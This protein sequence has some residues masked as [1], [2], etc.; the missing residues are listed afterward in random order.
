MAHLVGNV[1]LPYA[2]HT[3][4]T[5]AEVLDLVIQEAA[6]TKAR[7][8]SITKQHPSVA[9][10]PYKTGIN[11][12]YLCRLDTR[13]QTERIQLRFKLTPKGYRIPHGS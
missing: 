12:R 2:L 4:G 6:Y 3:R 1:V 13:L 11:P 5:F 7:Q 8:R 10:L 9:G